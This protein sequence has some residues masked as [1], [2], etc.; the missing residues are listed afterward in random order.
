MIRT[1]RQRSKKM[2]I[3]QFYSLIRLHFIPERNKFHC[4][5]EFF[6]ASREKHETAEDVWTRILQ[7]EKNCEIENVTSAELMASKFL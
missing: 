1:V 3:N 5:A 4:R 6:G 7:V 2:D